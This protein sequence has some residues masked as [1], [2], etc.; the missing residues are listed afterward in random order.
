M[1]FCQWILKNENS[2]LLLDTGCQRKRDNSN[3]MSGGM[4]YPDNSR[5]LAAGDSHM[6]KDVAHD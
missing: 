6:K 2:N 5:K 4:S 3:E 1:N